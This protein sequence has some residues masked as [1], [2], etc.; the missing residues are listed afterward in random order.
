MKTRGRGMSVKPAL[1][2]C[3]L[4]SMDSPLLAKAR[5]TS[6]VSP[7]NTVVSSHCDFRREFEKAFVE[8]DEKGAA[9]IQC[10]QTKEHGFGYLRE[11][12]SW[13]PLLCVLWIL[14]VFVSNLE[15]EGGLFSVCFM[16]LH[17][18]SVWHGARHM[19]VC[20]Q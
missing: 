15:V 19:T 1:D 12:W 14:C 13:Q 8:K 20:P 18:L 17:M 4:Q 7:S 16:R 10:S 9:S 2:Y 6:C 3:Y 5:D 11:R